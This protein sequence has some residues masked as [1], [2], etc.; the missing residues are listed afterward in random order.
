[1]AQEDDEKIRKVL[2]NDF[3]NNYSEYYCEGVNRDMIIA[4]LEKQDKEKSSNMSIKEKA[5]QIAW[6]TSK[7]YDPLLSKESWCEMAA[8]DMASWLENQS[9]QK[10]IPKY[11]IEDVESLVENLEIDLE[12][13]IDKEIETRWKGEYLFTSKFRESAKYFFELGLKAKGK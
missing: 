11:G 5:H 7:H 12:K 6:E 2:L 9:E 3:K 13:E 8:L 1:M 4:W 10:I